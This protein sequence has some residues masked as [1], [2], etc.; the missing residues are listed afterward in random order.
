MRLD[1]A[2]RVVRAFDEKEDWGTE[3]DYAVYPHYHQTTDLPANIARAQEMGGG[4]LKMNI[5]V[6]TDAAGFETP[7]L[8]DGF[9]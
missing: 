1:K 3:N 8:R 2:L 9:E 7:V 4:I 5:A 6:L